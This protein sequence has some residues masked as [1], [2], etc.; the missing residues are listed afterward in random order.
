MQSLSYGCFSTGMRD[1]RVIRRELF[2]F[3]FVAL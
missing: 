1:G 2:I 3:I